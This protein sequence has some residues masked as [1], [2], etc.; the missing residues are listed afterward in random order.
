MSNVTLGIDIGGTGIKLGLVNPQGKLSRVT[1]FKTPIH[2][3]ANEVVAL[4]ADQALKLLQSASPKRIK[5]IG[6]GCAGDV[7]PRR[8]VVRIS[9]NLKWKN[10][11]LKN[12]LSRR[13][14][15]PLFVDNDANVAAWAAYC[16]EARR[17]VKNLLCVT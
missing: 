4:V 15:R 7:D 2:S 12:L 8:G 17:R 1:R 9:P 13:L 14:R 6:I 16:V 3:R 10:V 11:P 5:G